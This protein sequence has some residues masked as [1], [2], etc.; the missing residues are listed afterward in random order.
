MITVDL[1]RRDLACV[2]T[3]PHWLFRLLFRTSSNE[4]FAV[5]IHCIGG[6]VK[7][8]YDYS[9]RLVEPSV[10]A[11]IQKAERELEWAALQL[12]RRPGLSPPG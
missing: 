9:G 12:P 3:A 5:R 6:G 8:I 11:A 1:M 10:L 2:I 4:R 7:W